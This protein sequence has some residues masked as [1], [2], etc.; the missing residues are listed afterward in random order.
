MSTAGKEC[1]EPSDMEHV[2]TTHS[3]YDISMAN[4]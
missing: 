3:L 4:I 2:L 1:V